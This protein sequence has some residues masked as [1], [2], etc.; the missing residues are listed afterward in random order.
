MFLSIA[1]TQF[2]GYKKSTS[3]CALISKLLLL[4]FRIVKSETVNRTRTLKLHFPK[5]ESEPHN[6]N[7]IKYLSTGTGIR[8][9]NNYGYRHDITNKLRRSTEQ[10]V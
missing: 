9:V 5:P 7:I 8:P 3:A 6:E 10:V 2:I 1:C 4:L